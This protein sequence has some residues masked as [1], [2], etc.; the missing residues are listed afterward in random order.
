MSDEDKKSIAKAVVDWDANAPRSIFFDDI[1]FSGDGWAESRH[2]FLDGNELMTRFSDVTSF[3]IAELGFGTAL[4]FLASWNLWRCTNKKDGAHLTYFSVEKYPLSKDEMQRAANNWPELKGLADKLIDVLP[5]LTTGL[6]SISI[7]CDVTLVLAFGDAEEI[8]C[9]YKGS[10]DAWFLDGFSPSKNPAMWSK[11]LFERMAALSKESATFSTFTVAGFVRRGLEATG[12]SLERRSGYGRK[13][14]MLCGRVKKNKQP[15]SLHRTRAP[16]LSLDKT[17]SLSPNAKIAILGGGIAGAS[18]A[19]ALKRRGYKPTIFDP[20]GLAGGASG[21]PAGLIMPRLDLGDTA[22]THFFKAAYIHTIRLLNSY[23]STIFNNIGA[24]TKAKD[25]DERNKHIKILQSKLLPEGWIELTNEGLFF[26]QAGV[27]NPIAYCQAL[28]AD[29]PVIRSRCHKIFRHVENYLLDIDGKPSEPFDGVIIANGRD[30]K[31]L[32]Q[33]RTLPI[34]GVAGQLDWFENTIPIDKAIT[35]GPYVAPAPD[36][37]MIAGATYEKITADQTPTSTPKASQENRDAAQALMTDL[38]LHEHT[39][40][41]RT[42]IRCQ[43]PDHLP[44]VGPIP[45]WEAYGADYDELR[46][47]VQKNYPFATYQPGLWILTGLGSRGLVTAP[48]CAEIIASSI[49]GTPPITSK[50]VADAIHPGRFFI[51]A[52]KRGSS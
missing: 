50:S 22:A 39:S 15:A 8:L 13:R 35:A 51:R 25:Q 4:N 33:T 12:F 41:P 49:A 2:V 1:Y 16:W 17:N 7:D 10:F 30:A 14:E 45:D 18:L 47:G 52:L 21:N 36:G 46:N 34:Y 48:Y 32:I 42:S 5:C 26:P 38:D 27:I 43:T 9:D 40:T 6:H 11:I 28:A 23:D 24:T 3:S 20:L 31:H 44:V 29:T 37:G 19:Q